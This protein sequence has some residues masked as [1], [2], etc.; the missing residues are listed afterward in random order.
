MKTSPQ[1]EWTG[2]CS[3][4]ERRHVSRRMGGRDG[5]PMQ[6]SGYVRNSQLDDGAAGR[7]RAVACVHRGERVKEREGR[8][9]ERPQLFGKGKIA[10]LQPPNRN[11][12]T[13]KGTESS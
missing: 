13:Y 8:G 11:G 12:K 5:E 1:M 6:T 2:G 4:N 10:K 7:G 3:P 9:G